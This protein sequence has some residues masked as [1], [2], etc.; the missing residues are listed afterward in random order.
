[1]RSEDSK[2]FSWLTLVVAAAIAYLSLSFLDDF[3]AQV[4]REW[5]SVLAHWVLSALSFPVTRMGTILET[6]NMRFDVVP[7]CNGSNMLKVLTAIGV[8]YCGSLPRLVLWQKIVAS[9]L[10]VPIAIV[11]NGVRVAALVAGSHEGV[12]LFRTVV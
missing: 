8:L 4:L 5:S 7:A 9:T 3:S 12:P 2:S 1:M 10:C 6:P 11:C